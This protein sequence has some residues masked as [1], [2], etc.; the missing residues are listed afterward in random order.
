MD[1]TIQANPQHRRSI[2]LKGFDDTSENGYFITLV[3]HHR[4]KLFGRIENDKMILN[5]LGKIPKD[6]WFKTAQLR[7]YVGLVD[8]EFGAMPNHIHGIIWIFNIIPDNPGS[9]TIPDIPGWGTACR[10]PTIEQFGKPV[11]GSIPTIIRAYKSAVTKN[12][13]IVRG[14]PSEPV[15]QRNYYEHIFETDQEYERIAAY[16]ANNTANWD[17]DKEFM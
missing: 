12:I 13:N 9:G 15:F 16:I 7:P 3:T 2:R 17:H 4:A 14:T 11:P 8:D 5:V 10:A 6:E 1:S